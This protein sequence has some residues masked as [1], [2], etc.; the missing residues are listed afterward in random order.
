M[1]KKKGFTIYY[2]LLCEG[3]TEYNLFAYLT[4]VKYRGLFA[5]SNIKFSDKVQ[6]VRSNVSQGKLNGA[7]NLSS[8]KAKYDE[9]KQKYSGQTLFFV[10]DKDL[11]DS[12]QIETLIQSGGDIVQFLIGNSEHLLLRL[13]GRTPRDT[14]DFANLKDFRDYCKT[15]FLKQF[16]KEAPGFKD[17]DFDLIFSKLSDE[18]VRTT[19]VEL[20]ATIS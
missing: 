6:I 18:E 20:F 9:I 2:L 8:F 4:R 15:E 17:A 14:S 5:N 3:T 11:D 10:L 1:E 13:D 7:G 12:T 16:G 19:F